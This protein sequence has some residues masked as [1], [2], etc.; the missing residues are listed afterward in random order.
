MK[1]II[2]FCLIILL[3]SFTIQSQIFKNGKLSGNVNIEVQSYKED[4]L[5]G[6]EEIK[7]KV[8]SNSYAN[9]LFQADNF[10][11]GVRFET[12]L[13]TLNGIDS[14]YNNS[15]DG[16][17]I[18][19]P[20]RFVKFKKDNI[21]ITA[22]NFYEQFGSGLILRTFEEKNLG[23]D[24]SIDGFRVRYSLQDNAINLTGIVGRQ[25][26]YWEKSSGIIRA[27]DASINVNNLSESL[28]K[29]KAKL[30]IGFGI[31]SKYQEDENPFYNLPE[32]VMA[33]ATRLN[34]HY[35]N[36]NIGSEYARKINDPSGDNGFIY[37]DGQALLV[38]MTYAKRGFAVLL[39]FKSVDNMSFRSDRNESLTNLNINYIPSITQNHVYSLAA[40]YPYATQ[41][42]GEIGYQ[43]EIMY[44]IKKKTAI[45]GK[46]GMNLSV[47][48][49]QV[50][51]IDKTVINDTIHIGESGTKGYESSLFAFG[52]ELYFQDFNILI[53][54]KFSK[55]VKANFKY[56]NFAYNQ[57]I[58]AGH[59]NMVYA[60][61]GIADITYKF[62]VRKSLRTE[63]QYLQT[64]Q[65][66]QD[67]ALLL[68]EYSI[69]PKWFF[70]VMDKYNFGNN[71]E[72]KRIHYYNFS[73][74]YIKNSTRIQLGYGKQNEGILCVGGVCRVVPAVNGLS[75]TLS[76]N[77]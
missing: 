46:Y 39:G 66:L 34:F 70:S 64:K 38:N 25:R 68:F 44:K 14:K 52:D 40:I 73:I 71:I 50:Y 32:N 31:V 63:I 27:F 18:G 20:Y 2:Y 11:F 59:N 6:A 53:K 26:H 21:E 36:I 17:G 35:K 74:S 16:T 29:K 45:G 12:Y 10:S 57:K 72:K 60:N 37:K 9:V 77:F 47:N 76:T 67:W 15:G 28:K 5:I 23:I 55:K 61:I 8:L 49:A 33:F 69:A 3:N 56:L 42:N 58:L 7:E 54:K 22:G 19:I 75:F 13:N 24:N 51:N 4:S 62:S 30:T 41:T 1:K 65:D 43:A 48:F